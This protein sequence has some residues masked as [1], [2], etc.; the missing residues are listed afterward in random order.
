MINPNE[1]RWVQNTRTKPHADKLNLLSVKRKCDYPDDCTIVKLTQLKMNH[2]NAD[3]RFDNGES[4][5][6]CYL[7]FI[8]GGQY[9]K[10]P[11]TN[12]W[13]YVQNSNPPHPEKAY[14]H[15]ITQ[16]YHM[17]N[18]GL[19]ELTEQML[20]IKKMLIDNIL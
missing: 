9:Q 5:G 1:I 4:S 14:Q 12:M 10:D 17:S 18:E 15:S 13:V 3:V 16:T 11:K 2:P 7:H 6:L 8:D 19:I 20:Y